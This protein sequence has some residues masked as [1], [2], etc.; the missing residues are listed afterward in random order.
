MAEPKRGIGCLIS[1]LKSHIINTPSLYP[2]YAFVLLIYNP[3]QFNGSFLNYFC[4]FIS[5]DNN[6]SKSTVK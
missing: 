2:I 4:V 5:E 6:Y 3:I 1:E